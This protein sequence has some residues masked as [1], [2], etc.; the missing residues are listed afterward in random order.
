MTSKNP[1]DGSIY[2]A[3]FN[4][5]D[6]SSEKVAVRLAD[7]GIKNAEVTNMWTGEKLGAVKGEVV[8]SL[9][10]HASVLYKLKSKK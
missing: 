4:I 8:V 6:N 9:N 3:L 2:L 5:S 10:A 7:F 1:K